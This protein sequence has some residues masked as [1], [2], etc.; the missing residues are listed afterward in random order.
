MT[1][2]TPNT[3]LIRED[4]LY[5]HPD[6]AQAKGIA[7]GDQVRLRSPRSETSLRVSLSEI[8]LPGVLF[9]TFHFP[10]AFINH[11]TS[12]VGDEFTLTPEFKVVAVDFE[13]VS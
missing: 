4:L 5:V 1:R 2:R 12:E 6:D 8:V 13:R 7:D 9:T 10:D 3:E 11:L